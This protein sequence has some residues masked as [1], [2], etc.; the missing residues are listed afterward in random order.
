MKKIV[1]LTFLMVPFFILA[2]GADSKTFVNTV[3]LDGDLNNVWNAI[4]DFSTMSVWD[5]SIVD[6]R[7]NDGLDKNKYCKVI[8][9]SGTIHDV[10]IVDLIEGQSYTVRY[11]LSS[12][13]VYIKRS[14]AS[15]D[16]IQFTETVWYTGISKRTFA[17]YKGD[18][19]AQ[20]LT[21]RIQ[22]FKKFWEE[23]LAEGEK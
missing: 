6:V 16:P 19:Y 8:A 23:D 14:L 13:N 4:T 21:D 10:E 3:N 7:C 9:G 17:K 11:K 18:D 1:K 20:V 22:D 15:E 12:G 2:Q 5:D